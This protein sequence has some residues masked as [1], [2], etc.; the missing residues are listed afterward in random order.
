VPITFGL[1]A[2]D[3][4]VTAVDHKPKTTTALARLRNVR[5]HP[6]VTV[7]VDHYDD[8][9]AE[10]WW[11]RGRGRA[12]VAEPSDPRWS[13]AIRALVDRYPQYADTAPA[14]DVI[15]IEISEWRGWAASDR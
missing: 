1:L 4:I 15:F 11:V 12:S 13:G 5:T 8:D 6:E 9:W 2:D 10:L 14:G 7:L 3:V